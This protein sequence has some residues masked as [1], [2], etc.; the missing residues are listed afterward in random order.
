MKHFNLEQCDPGFLLWLKTTPLWKLHQEDEK[1][2][3]VSY[4]EFAYE[5]WLNG[6]SYAG[7]GEGV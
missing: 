3:W 1:L 6:L 4:F 2:L 5:A 7:D